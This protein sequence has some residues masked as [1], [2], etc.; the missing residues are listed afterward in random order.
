MGFGSRGMVVLLGLEGCVPARLHLFGNPL[1]AA[2]VVR[3]F[4]CQNSSMR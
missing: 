1:A 2:F 3:V 4:M